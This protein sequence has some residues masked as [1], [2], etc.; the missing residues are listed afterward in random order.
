MRSQQSFM[1]FL[2]KDEAVPS[3]DHDRLCCR[4][5]RFSTKDIGLF[6]RHVAHHN[7][8]TFS[9]ALC[10]HVSF[11]KTES[12]KHVVSHTGSYP[13]RCSF[14]SYGAVRRDYMVK[15]INRLH[16]GLKEKD[17]ITNFDITTPTGELPSVTDIQRTSGWPEMT[18]HCMN[19]STAALP[20]GNAQVGYPGGT[21]P[22]TSTSSAIA[23]TNSRDARLTCYTTTQCATN[24]TPSVPVAKTKF[25]GAV[26]S[27]APNISHSIG[28]NQVQ[29][30]LRSGQENG[31]LSG[32]L[33][34]GNCQS[35]VGNS[36]P[37]KPIQKAAFKGV[38]AGFTEPPLRSQRSGVPEKPIHSK[39][40]P[41][42]Q[43]RLPVEMNSPLRPLLNMTAGALSQKN[44]AV[45]SIQ[46][47]PMVGQSLPA[48]NNLTPQKM[49]AVL[50]NSPITHSE[51]HLLVSTQKEQTTE[52]SHQPK[53]NPRIFIGSST[54]NA[55]SLSS[56]QVELLAPLNQPIQHNKPLTVSCPEEINIPAGC[57]V[58]LVEVKNVNGTRE[59]ELRLIPSNGIPQDPKDTV[60]S[61]S[62]VAT[63]NKLS[64]K[65][66][67]APESTAGPSKSCPKEKTQ[68]P[69]ACT[70]FQT[71]KKTLHPVH[72][73]KCSSVQTMNKQKPK[74]NGPPFKPPVAAGEGTELSSEGLPVISS[75]FS[76][77]PTPT[78]TRSVS[79]FEAEF[80]DST[81]KTN[82]QL[83]K[84]QGQLKIVSGADCKMAVTKKLKENMPSTEKSVV[85][86]LRIKKEAETEEKHK[87]DDLEPKVEILEDTATTEAC[88]GQEKTVPGRKPNTLKKSSNLN[89]SDLTENTKSPLKVAMTSN[90]D[91]ISDKDKGD[92]PSPSG[93]DPDKRICRGS[94]MYPKVTLQRI[95]SSLLESTKKVP[96]APT[97]EE[98]LTA[99][100]VLYCTL[101]NQNVSGGHEGA[102]KLILKR[103]FHDSQDQN[104]HA[105]PRKKHKKDKMKK[106]KPPPV[107]MDFQNVLPK[108]HELRLTPLNE[109]QLVKFPG[110]NQPVVVLNHPNPLVHMVSVGVQTLKNYKF[111][112]PVHRMQEQTEVS[113]SK[114]PSFKMKLKKVH[115]Q[116][117]QVIEL[118]LRGVSEKLL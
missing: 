34:S 47:N 84:L 41:K 67:V 26:P 88:G 46:T 6:R 54:E 117:Y 37:E 18:E 95:P 105:P 101:S 93:S 45:Q 60:E 61:P 91:D 111:I 118:V 81:L 5:C 24:A 15:H 116:K 65:C 13:Y 11:S 12:Q 80:H 56:V 8:V 68:P 75:V 86:S 79:Q 44:V 25:R 112:H 20:K 50:S 39:I 59:L 89:T 85:C 49:T 77:C 110:P 28:N 29:V 96:K 48:I 17:F 31:N 100:P 16:K 104:H 23:K 63:A 83:I 73:P 10:S 22:R 82:L 90:I 58:E 109:D 42:V 92:S 32:S 30:V 3:K 2:N 38:P 27:C 21:Q 33:V 1:S 97:R 103:D 69:L 115:G 51:R 107:V 40:V 53:T 78:S 99:R 66:Q 4:K 62:P 74:S 71:I 35:K 52:K 72:K 64:F 113:V 114:Q 98:S 70:D 94:L 57:L 7:E 108:G 9:C 76:L 55:S 19:P 36:K 102:I 106:R 87:V 43:V 14:C